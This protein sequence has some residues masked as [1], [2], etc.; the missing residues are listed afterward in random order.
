MRRLVEVTSR[1]LVGTSDFCTTTT[2]VIAAD[3][4]TC[5]VVD[6]AA[7]PAEIGE[8]AADL[9]ELGLQVSAG[10]ATHPHWDHVLWSAEL[11]DVPR[12]ATAT[13]V[14]VIDA[15]RDE[16][17]RLAEE[18][19]PGHDHTLFGRLTPLPTNTSTI[20]WPGPTVRVIEHHAHA[21]GHAALHI[22]GEGVLLTGDMC[23]DIEIPLLDLR[24][25][26][27][28][29]DYRHALDVFSAVHGVHRVVPG[30]GSVGDGI[31][32]HRRIEADRRY[33]DELETGRGDDDPRLT[34][35]WLRQSHRSH[36]A[37]MAA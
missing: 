18:S 34:E 36:L 24:Q 7:Q 13:T 17:L 4:G 5:L 20:P 8:L 30:H 10:F 15:Q 19:A 22:P 12:Y 9:G 31:E 14:D 33:L 26:D 11:G 6:P 28:V 1:V 16:A 35:D 21:P 27:P 32:L 3:D 25:P 2:T 37:H 29:G 23:S